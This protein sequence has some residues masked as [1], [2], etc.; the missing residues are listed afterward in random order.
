MGVE[1]DKNRFVGRDK[2]L[3]SPESDWNQIEQDLAPLRERIDAIDR[4]ILDLINERARAAQK[5][6][7]LKSGHQ[8]DYYIPSREK[9]IF[10]RL[11]ELN[12]GP[13]ADDAVQSVYREIISA[14]RSLETKLTVAYL[15]PEGSYHHAAATAHFGRSS[16]FVPTNTISQVFEEVERG[17]AEYGLVAIEN[18][19]EGSVNETLDKLVNSNVSIVG[20]RYLPIS[21]N[22]ISFAELHEIEKVYSHPQALAQCRNWLENNLAN[23]P[24]VQAP[25]TTKGVQ[26]CK[27][28]P[29]AA[30]IAGVLAS[31]IFEVP[32]LVRGIE[33]HPDNTTRFYILGRKPLAPSGDDKVS[34]AVFIRDRPGALYSILEPFNRLEINLTNL[35]SRPSRLEIWQYMFFLECRGHHQEER[36]Q[37]VIHEIEKNSI[38]IKVFGSYPRA[39]ESQRVESSIG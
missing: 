9:A 18:S 28:E 20:E 22:L 16:E 32:I 39:Q 19:I 17:R 8:C 26:L 21:H 10:E 15:G 13:L 35:A 6:G 31:D 2:A 30:A 4:E 37:K 12:Q 33:D 24:L 29:K 36:I 7:H 34:M 38:Y 3:N 23:V 5:I 27:D 14:C 1:F 11:S 25:S